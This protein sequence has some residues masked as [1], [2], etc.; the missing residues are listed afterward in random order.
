MI[1]PPEMRAPLTVV[2]DGVATTTADVQRGMNPNHMDWNHITLL[3]DMAY[4]GDIPNL[5]HAPWAT[6]LV[7]ARKPTFIT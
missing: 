6:P 5:A 4:T 3:H 7:W 1:R 2:F